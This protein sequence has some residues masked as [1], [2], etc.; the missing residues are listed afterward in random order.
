MIPS[1]N[2][3]SSLSRPDDACDTPRQ[4]C[5]PAASD[6]ALMHS[7]ESG[8]I[9]QEE[10]VRAALARVCDSRNLDEQIR[11]KLMSTEDDN[12]FANEINAISATRIGHPPEQGIDTGHGL[13]ASQNT[14]PTVL[15][16]LGSL[17]GNDYLTGLLSAPVQSW[18]YLSGMLAYVI[19]LFRIEAETFAVAP[20]LS[21][22]SYFDAS[23]DVLN[24]RSRPALLS[25]TATPDAHADG[26]S[27][28]A[29]THGQDAIQAQIFNE[30]CEQDDLRHDTYRGHAGAT[31]P[32]PLPLLARPLPLPVRPLPLSDYVDPS[33]DGDEAFFW[34][35]AASQIIRRHDGARR[36]VCPDF[37]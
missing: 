17:F 7:N 29:T 37:A 22:D 5:L 14:P 12:A 15:S 26:A 20:P 25:V 8:C 31:P 35:D 33:G 16:Y 11:A 4:A 10:A 34:S 19:S 28:D 3:V 6:A 13:S 2:A 18:N 36:P 21:P 9:Y 30:I 23:N 27:R 32:S 24:E 1:L